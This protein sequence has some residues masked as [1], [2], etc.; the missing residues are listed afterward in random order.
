M[1][2]A[3]AF[4]SRPASTVMH[5]ENEALTLVVPLS[6]LTAFEGMATADDTEVDF[7]GLEVLEEVVDVF[8]IALETVGVDRG[9]DD[10]VV[11]GAAINTALGGREVEV[12][13]PVS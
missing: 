1:A 9:A 10:D 12:G 3:P 8:E 13:K 7:V 2:S 5:P 4:T 6:V 11:G